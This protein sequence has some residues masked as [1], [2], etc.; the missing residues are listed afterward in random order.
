[1]NR[2]YLRG[3]IEDPEKERDNLY[4]DIQLKSD[5]LFFFARSDLRRHDEETLREEKENPSSTPEEIK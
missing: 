1:M 4:S 2:P 5:F 3:W